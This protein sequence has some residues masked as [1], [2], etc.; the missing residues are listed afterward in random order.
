MDIIDNAQRTEEQARMSA[1]N[2]AKA[3]SNRGPAREDYAKCG[4]PIPAAR[5]EAVPGCQLCVE[6]QQEQDE[7]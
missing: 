6:C 3:V 4:E 7:S 2:R 5:R 1:L